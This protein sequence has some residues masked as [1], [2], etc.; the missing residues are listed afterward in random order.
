MKLSDLI[1]K[2]A[3]TKMILDDEDIVKKYK[4]PLEFYLMQ[5]MSIDLYLQLQTSK[6]MANTINILKEVVLDEAGAKVITEGN[7]IKDLVVL[8]KMT[9]K[10]LNEMG[11]LAEAS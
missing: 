11:N 4:E 9:T 8:L 10:I 3:L 5:P 2:P 7:T 1:V 6:D